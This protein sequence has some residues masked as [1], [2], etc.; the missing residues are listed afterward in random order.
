MYTK[1]VILV[2]QVNI[3]NY[4]LNI[5]S[6]KNSIPVSSSLSYYLPHPEPLTCDLC[7]SLSHKEPLTCDLSYYLPHIEPV[8]CDLGYYTYISS[9]L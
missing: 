1:Y 5:L 6:F 4:R 9:H 3:S 2:K 8:T 7:Y